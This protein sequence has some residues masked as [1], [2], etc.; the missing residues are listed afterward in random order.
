MKPMLFP[1]IW[2][3]DKSVGVYEESKR[4]LDQS[5][6]EPEITRVGWTYHH[7]GDLIPHTME[8]FWSGHFFPWLE[9]WEEIQISCNLA[10]FGF[11][12]QAKVS[13]RGGLELGLLSVYWNLNDRGV[14]AWSRG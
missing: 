7:V 2:H 9:S 10:L 13:L 5:G 8:N 11:Y 6:L 1:F 14:W 3:P 4:F 12:K